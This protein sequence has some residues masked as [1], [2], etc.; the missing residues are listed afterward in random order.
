MSR[1]NAIALA[2]LAAFVAL[3]TAFQKTERPDQR[4]V[5]NDLRD[6]INETYGRL[7][8]TPRINCGPCTR[9]ALAFRKQWKERFGDDL[10]LVCVM[11]PGGDECGHVALK[12][13]AGNYYDGGNGVM[14]PQQLQSMFP[15]L[16]LEEMVDV[17]IA[18]LDQLVGGLD[19][20]RYPQCPHY[21]EELTN[22][23]IEKHLTQLP[24]G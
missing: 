17:D 7:E 9:F 12:L 11:S 14:T 21:S 5:L 24:R 20:A 18:R 1:R 3:V 15:T 2:S 19:H 16:H 4:T 22:A 6:E 23:I 10:A 13:P 8:G